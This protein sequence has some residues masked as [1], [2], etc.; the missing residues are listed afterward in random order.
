LSSRLVG[1]TALTLV[2]VFAGTAFALEPKRAGQESFLA[3]AVFAEGQLWVLSDAGELSSIADGEDLR[4][5]RVL[6]EPALDLCRWDYRP[7]VITCKRKGCTDWILRRWAD[8]GWYTEA[9]IPTQNDELVALS[10]A[11]NRITLLTTRRIIGLT[12]DKRSTLML[13][14]PLGRGLVTSMQ[15]TPDQVFVGMNAGER[16]GGLRRIDRKSGKITNVARNATGELCGGPL[17]SACDPVNGIASE[18]WR[19]HCVAVAVGLVH[20]APHGRIVEVCGDKVQRLYFK[21]YEV[22]GLSGKPRGKS[23]EPFSTVA[24]FGL[25]RQGDA[26]WAAGIDGIYRIGAHGTVRSTPLPR[27]KEIGGIR[28]SFDSPNVV[29]VLTNINQRRSISGS[30]PMI[31]PRD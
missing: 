25:T 14:E 16:G 20:Y 10:C 17:N 18:P 28:V 30:A 8:G 23:D 11:G 7:A 5:E 24:F 31:V 6:P 21:P 26:L 22:E 12:G 2:A 13:S 4:V 29:L 27:F 3:R 9:K 19:P 15:V 1:V